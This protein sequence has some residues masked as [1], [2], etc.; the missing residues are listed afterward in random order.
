MQHMCKNLHNFEWCNRV[1]CQRKKGQKKY[2]CPGCQ[3]SIDKFVFEKH[4][5]TCTKKQ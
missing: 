2:T 4:L 1:M 5:D 3:K